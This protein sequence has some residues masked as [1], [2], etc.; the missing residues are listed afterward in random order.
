M[1]KGDDPLS[2][3]AEQD[4]TDILGLSSGYYCSSCLMFNIRQEF[5]CSGSRF[6]CRY[7]YAI[8]R[9]SGFR[10]LENFSCKPENS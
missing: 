3:Y 1:H 8:Q 2:G 4:D 7:K 5:I 6:M 9:I 10:E